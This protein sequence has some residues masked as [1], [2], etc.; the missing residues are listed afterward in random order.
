MWAS[1][2]DRHMGFLEVFWEVEAD[3]LSL[4]SMVVYGWLYKTGNKERDGWKIS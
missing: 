3:L 4:V 2:E 1:E